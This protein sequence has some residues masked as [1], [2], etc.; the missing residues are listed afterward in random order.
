[1]WP[2]KSCGNCQASNSKGVWIAEDTGQQAETT[3]FHWQEWQENTFLVGRRWAGNAG[4]CP[5]CVTQAGMV[6]HF[7]RASNQAHF[8]FRDK[9]QRIMDFRLVSARNKSVQ[10]LTVVGPG[11]ATYRT[12]VHT[13]ADRRSRDN[14][15]TSG[16]RSEKRLLSSCSLERSPPVVVNRDPGKR[17]GDMIPDYRKLDAA[18]GSAK[19]ALTRR[20]AAYPRQLKAL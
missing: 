3:E 18:S 12:D 8:Y 6:A 7:E 10:F 5:W 2:T 20:R 11:L 19:R 13:V 15:R 9:T 1:M 16:V 14:A 4:G 17:G